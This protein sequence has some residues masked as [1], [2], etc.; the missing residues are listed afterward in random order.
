MGTVPIEL[1]QELCLRLGLERAVETGTFEG[2]GTRLLA[3]EFPTVVSI[4]LS[5]PLHEAAKAT[6][7]D[8]P[9]VHLLQGNSAE[10][11]PAVAAAGVP[12][13]Y[14]LDGHWCARDSRLPAGVEDQCPVLAELSAIA[15][16]HPL[17]CV[18]IDDAVFFAA[19]PSPP[20][21]A[22]QWPTLIELLNA[23]TAAFPQ[24]HI[25]VVHNYAI[26]VPVGGKPSV[27]NF[28]HRVAKPKLWQR[29]LGRVR[30]WTER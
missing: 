1:A 21:R 25:T 6:L 3:R 4:E 19:S 17:D 14:W 30:S 20:Y 29:V 18:I 11:L 22:D 12:T 23:M 26:A 16:G 9:N 13:L 27:D 8:L 7:S 28:G 10:K 15:G 5:E 24:H 2:G